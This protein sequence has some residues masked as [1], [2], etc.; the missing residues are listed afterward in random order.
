MARA[1]LHWYYFRRCAVYN[2]P[3]TAFA[4]ALTSGIAFLPDTPINPISTTIAFTRVFLVT[5]MSLGSAFGF[6]M[7]HVYLKNEYPLYYNAGIR[8]RSSIIITAIANLIIGVS[9]MIL[10]WVLTSR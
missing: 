6:V 5:Y 7:Y 3:I 4:A 1:R 10:I 2:L 8:M 9:L